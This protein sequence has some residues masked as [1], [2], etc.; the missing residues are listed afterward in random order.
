MLIS[1]IGEAKKDIILKDFT[2]LG[3]SVAQRSLAL[4]TQS[5]STF[6][7]L[8]LLRDD[9]GGLLGDLDASYYASAPR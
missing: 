5:H 4:Q 3:A 2:A 1:I 7:T 8:S 9:V 6:D